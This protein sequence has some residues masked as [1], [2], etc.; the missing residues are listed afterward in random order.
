MRRVRGFAYECVEGFVGEGG[1]F[2]VVDGSLA[3]TGV[4]EDDSDVDDDAEVDDDR[5][6][7][8]EV[9]ESSEPDD[10][11]RL[12]WRKYLGFVEEGDRDTDGK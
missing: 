12:L 6:E 7:P 8:L 4:D 5:E 10:A 1:V 9:N 3:W 2:G 11:F